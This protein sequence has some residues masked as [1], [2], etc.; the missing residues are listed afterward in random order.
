MKKGNVY[1]VCFDTVPGVV[2][3]IGTKKEAEKF[4][5]SVQDIDDVENWTE[6]E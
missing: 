1:G 3:E 2:F 5:N 4:A 6:V